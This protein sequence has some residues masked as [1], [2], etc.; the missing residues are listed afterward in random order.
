MISTRPG[1]L[2]RTCLLLLSA[3]FLLSVPSLAPAE[4]PK[5]VRFIGSIEEGVEGKKIRYPSSLGVDP[6]SGEIY[7]VDSGNNRIVVCDSFF[8]PVYVLGKS[9]GILSPNCLVWTG[10][11]D[12]LIA[13]SPHGTP[14]KASISVYSV[15]FRN[16]ANILFEG[17]SGADKFMP[18]RLAEDKKNQLYVAGQDR[19]GI[20]I[21]DPKG[22]Y[23]RELVPEDEI[24][25]TKKPVRI[26]DMDIADNGNI[27]LLSPEAGRVFVYSAEGEFLYKFGEKGGSSGKLSQPQGLA[28]DEQRRR[29]YIVDYMR[30]SVS[31]YSME[32]EFLF[33]F[34]G[35]GWGPGWFQYPTDVV[36]DSKQRVY[37]S[38]K[39]NH[40]VQVFGTI[41]QYR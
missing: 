33:E 32:G 20:V 1:R 11:G 34:G 8:Y 19:N 17:F 31:A 9:R 14:R 13:Q 36:V 2:A 29:L 41:R 4:Q 35:R 38:D 18:I 21:L 25:G 5:D 26:A 39:F 12:L 40:R 7:I 22:K 6:A 10:Q 15:T 28:I 16:R 24:A 30:H 3:F 23:L 27:F 37:V